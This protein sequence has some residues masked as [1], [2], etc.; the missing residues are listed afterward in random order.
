MKNLIKLLCVLVLLTMATR[1]SAQKF[2]VKAGLNL[3]KMLLKND[4]GTYSDDLKMHPGFH[5][6]ATAEF[7]IN[8]MFSFE[9][10][11]LL[12]TKGY[13]YERPGSSDY[14]EKLNLFYFE[15]PLNAKATFDV[16]GVKIY[17]AFGPYL[18]LGLSGK[19]KTKTS[20][21]SDNSTVNWGSDSENDDLKRFDLGINVGAGVEIKSILVGINY[22]LGLANISSYTDGGNKA[23]N[24]VFAISFGYKLGGE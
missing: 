19:Y 2:A 10:G 8:D 23:K 5:V 16:E 20:G 21:V 18:G 11:L 13:N 12:S 14:T 24:R 17:G 3:S 7:P 15:I 1:T 9:P 6:G 4:N 22:G